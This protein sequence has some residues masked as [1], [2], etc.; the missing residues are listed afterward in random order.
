MSVKARP[1]GAASVGMSR[2]ERSVLAAA[3]RLSARVYSKDRITALFRQEVNRALALASSVTP[4]Q[5][6]R[7]VRIRRFFGVEADSCRWS[8]F[9][10]LEHLVI[11]NAAIIAL[12]PRL[13]SG[14]DA[15]LGLPTDDLQPIADAGPEQIGSLATLAERYA[16]VVGKLG[17]LHAGRRCH[18]PWFGTLSAAQW[19]ALAA[20]HAST[21]RR[22]IERI[23]RLLPRERP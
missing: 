3:I 15:A 23:L 4:E 10:T 17:N 16:E 21:H 7:R 14:H 8:V 11:A 9:M 12:L 18:H 19:H 2:L 13:Y 22:Q 5:G 6:Q 1:P 20:F